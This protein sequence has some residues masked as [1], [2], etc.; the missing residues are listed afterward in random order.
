MDFKI[1]ARLKIEMLIGNNAI[2]SGGNLRIKARK[3][4]LSL[5]RVEYAFTLPAEYLFQD[6]AGPRNRI[7]PDLHFF[8]G[9]L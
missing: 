8:G 1:Y 3:R 7:F 2:H 5:L 4:A 6:I 9:Y